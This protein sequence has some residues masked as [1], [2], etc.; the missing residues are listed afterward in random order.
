IER[1]A[2]RRKPRDQVPDRGIFLPCVPDVIDGRSCPHGG[3]GNFRHL[4]LIA[5]PIGKAGIGGERQARQG[6]S[7]GGGPS[8]RPTSHV[9]PPGSPRRARNPR[10][11]SYA[12]IAPTMNRAVQT[13]DDRER[14]PIDL[15]VDLLCCGMCVPAA[16]LPDVPIRIGKTI[17]DAASECSTIYVM[18]QCHAWCEWTNNI[19]ATVPKK[20]RCEEAIASTSSPSGRSIFAH[21]PGEV[22]RNGPP[23]LR[24]LGGDG[25][26]TN[27]QQVDEIGGSR[28]PVALYSCPGSGRLCDA[29]R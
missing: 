7:D 24:R 13:A 4:D 20:G 29:A 23:H 16:T 10:E 28:R 25:R 22:Q 27:E 11:G 19:S 1:R 12:R 9:S 2:A 5:R 17:W 21:R 14:N 8:E 3:N 6:Q 15:A 18:D 26:I